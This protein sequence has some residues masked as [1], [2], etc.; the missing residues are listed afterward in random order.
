MKNRCIYCG[1]EGM[2]EHRKSCRFNVSMEEGKKRIS[3]KYKNQVAFQC[4][5]CKRYSLMMKD[6]YEK[7]KVNTMQTGLGDFS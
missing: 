3:R 2:L 4:M 6:E 1:Y 7:S 5:V